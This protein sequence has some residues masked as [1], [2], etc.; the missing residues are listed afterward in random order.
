VL[1]RLIRLYPARWRARYGDELAQL[2]LDLR[3]SRPA[4]SLAADLVIGAFRTHLQERTTMGATGHRVLRQTA[5]IAGLVWLGLVLEIVL[6]NVAFPTRRDH[7]GVPVLLS[8]LCVFAALFLIGLLAARAGAGRRG[9][10]LAG[11][12]AGVAIGALTVATFFVVDNVWLDVVAHQQTKID[13]FT[14]SGATSMRAY[15]NDGLI[16]AAVFLTVAFGVFGAGL[17]LAG[18]LAHRERRAA[19]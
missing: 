9:Q 3:S 6:T 2:V 11:V 16:G 14:R 18:G 7:D 8:Y 4:A 12:V 19:G 13:G 15:V 10:I 17:S 5:L 1:D